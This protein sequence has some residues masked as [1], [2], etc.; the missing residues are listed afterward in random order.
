MA[1]DRVPLSSLDMVPLTDET[2][3]RL[4]DAGIQPKRGL[5]E[6]GAQAVLTM[7]AHVNDDAGAHAPDC[8]Q[9][10][11]TPSSAL[12]AGCVYG[13]RCWR[14]DHGYLRRLQA[15]G[16]PMPIGVPLDVVKARMADVDAL[17]SAPPPPS[18]KRAP[19]PPKKRRA[20]PPPP[21]RKP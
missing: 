9:R 2:R 21:L 12:C 6:M 8:Y 19:P 15:G 16:A 13:P 1:A 5:S 18:R 3:Q 7:H 20:P 14:N 10:K 4:I 11:Y 17:P